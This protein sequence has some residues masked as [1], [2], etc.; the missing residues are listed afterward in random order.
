MMKEKLLSICMP[1]FNGEKV[2][3][4]TLGSIIRQY[5]G[6]FEIVLCDDNSEDSTY[7]ILEEFG[8]IYDFIRIYKND[9][10]LGMDENFQKTVL[11]AKGKYIWLFG[12]DDLLQP[13]AV[14]KVIAVLE[15]YPDVGIIYINY[16]QYTHDFNNVLCASALSRQ[17]V[18]KKKQDIISEDIYF[19]N[20]VDYFKIFDS[21]PSFLPATVMRRTY[22]DSSKLNRF[23]GTCYVQVGNML[24]SMN[25]G[26]IYI[27][28]EPLIKGRIPLNQWQMDGNKHFEIFTGALKM[29]TI[30]YRDRRNPIP[31]KIYRLHKKRYLLNFF[32]LTWHC[33]KM[34]L[35]TDFNHLKM[36]KFIYGRGHVYSFY[37]RTIF[38]MPVF[39]MNVIGIPLTVG[40]I[41][42]LFLLTK[43]NIHLGY[44][45]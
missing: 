38:L 8:I 11:S 14:D 34:G 35:T 33:K 12:Q 6:K 32:F 23:K 2:I 39:L 45:K 26:S 19:K 16:S 37:F 25:K 1:V 3:K 22:W 18:N 41:C 31:L 24:L 20:S 42:S 44:K 17:L 15:K 4:E 13:G 7:A 43:L 10:N 40:K 29:L 27:I 21:L 30:V 5:N 28:V 36:I 9:E